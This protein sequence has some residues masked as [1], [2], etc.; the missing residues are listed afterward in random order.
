MTLRDRIWPCDIKYGLARSNIA[1]RDQIWPCEIEYSL[2]R[3]NIALRDRIWSCEIEYA[4]A[5]LLMALDPN[6]YLFELHQKWCFFSA[7]SCKIGTIFGAAE[8][9]LSTSYFVRALE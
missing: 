1:L 9:K 2:P 3:S 5:R 7:A 4:L 6:K 8:I